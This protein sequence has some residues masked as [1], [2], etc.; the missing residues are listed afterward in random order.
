MDN[1]FVKNLIYDNIKPIIALTVLVI[2]VVVCVF[3]S[4]IGF[5]GKIF[6]RYKEVEFGPFKLKGA[7]VNKNG[8]EEISGDALKFNNTS[9]SINTF[10]GIFETL[11]NAELKVIIKNCINISDK[12]NKYREEF[13]KFAN[14]KISTFATNL[15]HEYYSRLIKLVEELQPDSDKKIKDTKEFSFISE[16]LFT[17]EH[18]ITTVL[19]GLI[20]NEEI[21]LDNHGVYNIPTYTIDS[22]KSCIFTCEDPVKLNETNL[23]SKT[24]K[25]AILEVNEN[26]GREV[27]IFLTDIFNAKKRMLE[28]QQ[29]EMTSMDEITNKSISNIINGVLSKLFNYIKVDNGPA[30]INPPGYCN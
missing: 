23:D 21:D 29:K 13:T 3:F 30:P 6:G 16:L 19:K 26:L 17:F 12:I 24:F 28:K 7:L 8:K 22:V 14:E 9:I 10:I 18:R 25:K 4:I 2:I 15:K 20:E 1:D 5:I 27:Q 11:L